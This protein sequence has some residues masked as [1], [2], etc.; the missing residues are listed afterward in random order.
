[1]FGLKEQLDQFKAEIEHV[2]IGFRLDNGLEP[3]WG[4]ESRQLSKLFKHDCQQV[5]HLLRDQ[6]QY[7]HMLADPA[8]TRRWLKRQRSTLHGMPFDF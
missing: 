6:A 5:R 3:G 8:V 2:D 4:V 1:M 7:M